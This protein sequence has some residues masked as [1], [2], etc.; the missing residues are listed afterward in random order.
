MIYSGVIPLSDCVV[1]PGDGNT[2]DALE[3]GKIAE[4]LPAPFH[5]CSKELIVI[6]ADGEQ[7]TSCKFE[8]FLGKTYPIRAGKIRFGSKVFQLKNTV[9][10]I[11]QAYKIEDLTALQDL[12]LD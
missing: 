6:I 10:T 7:S 3:P 5:H 8:I 4:R 12:G 11:G 1:D 2:H 9:I